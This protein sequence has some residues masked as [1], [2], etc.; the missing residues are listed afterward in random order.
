MTF[1]DIDLRHIL[2][3]SLSR[4]SLA[5][6]SLFS[7]SSSFNAMKNGWNADVEAEK[8][9]IAFFESSENGKV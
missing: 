8:A 2:S 7:R 9:E 5:F 3:L 4:F 1:R 6:L